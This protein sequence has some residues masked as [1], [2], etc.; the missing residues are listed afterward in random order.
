MQEL[1]P[2]LKLRGQTN[3]EALS[4]KKL[5]RDA[6]IPVGDCRPC[7]VTVS[8]TVHSFDEFETPTTLAKSSSSNRVIA[9][10]LFFDM[11]PLAP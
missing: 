9:C 10:I 5:T 2:E 8:S 3:D 4:L 7:A 11:K 1:E 6:K